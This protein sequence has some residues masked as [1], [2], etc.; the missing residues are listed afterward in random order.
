MAWAKVSYRREEVN[1]AGRCLIAPNSNA[2]DIERAL[3]VVNNW[4]AAHAFPLN[5][6]QVNLRR[7]ARSVDGSAVV[8]QR[9]KRLPAIDLKLRLLP[10][11][12]LT[13]MQDI[14]GCR[15]IV[16]SVPAVNKLARAYERSQFKHELIRERRLYST[17]ASVGLSRRSLGLSLLQ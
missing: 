1:G 11:L 7:S 8:A 12:N 4:R 5:T 14:G 9:I 6:F 17:A 2:E 3:S 13:Q 16:R 10:T 15:A